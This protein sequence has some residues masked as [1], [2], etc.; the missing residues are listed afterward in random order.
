LGTHKE[1]QDAVLQTMHN[2][3]LGGHSGNLVTYQKINQLFA[4]PNM[5]KDIEKFMQQCSTCQQ[6]KS[7]HCKIP[8]LLMLLYP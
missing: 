6:A 8:G 7:E 1:A 5:R 3:G 2:S 4:W